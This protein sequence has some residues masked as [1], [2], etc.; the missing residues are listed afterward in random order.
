VV[1]LNVV[2]LVI[3]PP[4]AVTVMVELPAGVEAVVL[5]VMVEEQAG[6]QEAVENEAVAPV[7]RPEAENETAWALPDAKVVP[8]ELVTEEPATTDL[9]P[10]LAREKLKGWLTIN[11]ALASALGLYPLLNVFALTVELLVKGI[12]PV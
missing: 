7:G 5:M 10:E 2:V 1:R 12:A 6:L 3:P 9:S 11:E 4:V 8:I